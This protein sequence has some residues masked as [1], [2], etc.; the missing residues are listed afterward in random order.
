MNAKSKQ[1]Q[2]FK[3]IKEERSKRKK[4]HL[5]RSWRVI[6]RYSPSLGWR[7]KESC[8]EAQCCQQQE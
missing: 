7:N 6:K 4:N 1:K 8:A 3:Q 5:W 2:I